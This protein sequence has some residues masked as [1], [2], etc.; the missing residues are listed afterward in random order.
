MTGDLIRIFFCSPDIAFAEP[1]T[2]ALGAGFQIRATRELRWPDVGEMGAYDVLLLDLQASDRDNV[3][4]AALDFLDNSSGS[5][6]PLPVVAILASDDRV[7]TLRL[8]D[9]GVHL[10]LASPPDMI[11]LRI[12]L[13]R[14][15]RFH[16]LEK[17]AQELRAQEMKITATYTM[18][19]V[20]GVLS[21]VL[22]LAQKV[23][24]CDV[25]V[26]ITG[27]TGTGKELW[28]RAIHRMSSRA[29]QPFVG[30][31]CAN[32]PETL[33]EDE[34]FGHEKG[35]FTGA[36]NTRRGR[37]ELADR[38]TLFLDEIGDLS[39]GLQPKFL[40]VVQERSF[41]RLGGS[42]PVAVDVRMICATHHN[43]HEMVEQGKFRE[44]LF[45][46][47][48]VVQLHLPP[49]RERRE[50]IP[51]LAHHFMRQFSTQ[52]GKKT[53]R[54]SGLALQALEEC[55]W[56]GNVRELENVVQRAVV[57]AE[58]STI[59]LSHL[60]EKLKKGF[61]DSSPTHSYDL[62]IREF[63][64]RLVLRTLRQCGWKKTE[65]ARSLGIARNY[66]HRLINQLNIL[67]EEAHLP[68]VVNN[69]AAAKSDI[70]N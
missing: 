10:I 12:A 57:L 11:E 13:R 34:L 41:E 45:Y 61:S 35:A 65:T 20:E 62:E 5:K 70:V 66:L 2:H 6:F 46:R 69:S 49:L 8:M 16:Q 60:P 19:G 68:G 40:R 53:K 21:E 14:A 59:E 58:D 23:A 3:V 24:P 67:P 26:L 51:E 7:L 55:S 17:E 56:P 9:L 50:S 48:N 18:V 39:L 4:K 32:L 44:D 25:T 1:L 28:A 43:L 37:F 27:E 63:K 22:S 42:K 47:L 38:G 15:C 33:I 31:S 30:F 64:K 36:S 54:F 29:A 52:F